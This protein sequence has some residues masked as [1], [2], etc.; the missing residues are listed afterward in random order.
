MR[1]FFWL[2]AAG[3]TTGCT[4]LTQFDPEGQRCDNEGQCLFD[5][6]YFCNADKICTKLG[7]DAGDGDAGA[8][9]QV[10]AGGGS[11]AGDAGSS[12]DAGRTDAGDAGGQTDAGATDAGLDGGGSD[13]G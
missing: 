7:R 11:D 3:I 5:A 2:A 1:R 12:S 6:G 9:Q 8:L 10:D 13:G 4:L